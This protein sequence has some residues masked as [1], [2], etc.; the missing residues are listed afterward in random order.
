MR[1]VSAT[2]SG[3]DWFRQSALD[4][5]NLFC[6]DD[7]FEPKYTDQHV[8]ERAVPE[9]ADHIFHLRRLIRENLVWGFVSVVD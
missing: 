8:L 5:L 7:L 4:A 6:R 9:V 3:D 1:P 2:Y